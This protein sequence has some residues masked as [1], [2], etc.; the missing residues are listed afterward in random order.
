[1]KSIN[2]SVIK[3]YTDGSCNP[4]QKV[5]AWA[6]LIFIDDKKIVLQDTVSET[7]H[8]RM[9]LIA[10]I[11]SI[12]YVLKEIPGNKQIKIYT[13]SQYV[14]KIPDRTQKLV[15]K[16]FKTKKGVEI[17]NADLVQDIIELLNSATAI[18]FIKVKAHQKTT[19]LPNYNREV[20]KLSRKLVRQ[21]I[22]KN[23]Y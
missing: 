21:Y 1:M 8:N 23:Q 7:T 2:N 12:E 15:S 18:E 5:G 22:S 9:E 14:E 17:Q 3:I 13:D 20:D 6:A 10:V 4:Q 19:V 11:K 16:D